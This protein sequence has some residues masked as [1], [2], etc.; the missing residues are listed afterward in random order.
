MHKTDE[1]ID[2]VLSALSAIEP[3]E[4]LE[5]R[6]LTALSSRVHQPAHTIW[7]FN[8]LLVWPFGAVT[9][10]VLA[11]VF[12]LVQHQ[13]PKP[14]NSVLN[15]GSH[16]AQPMQQPHPAAQSIMRPIQT[17]PHQRRKNS[18][19]SS[20][21]ISPLEER[22]LLETRA[23]SCPAPEAPPTTEERLLASIVQH[24]TPQLFAMLNP[25]M[26]HREEEA[27]EAEFERFF[28][29]SGAENLPH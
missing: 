14:V 9:L 19:Q 3:N 16:T 4:S 27:E 17:T 21:E 12:F 25:E 5:R 7:R 10:A 11:L 22:A 26:R 2:K 24:E 6:V 15:A 8:P 28:D 13:Q 1:V 29:P 18:M 20:P 23:P